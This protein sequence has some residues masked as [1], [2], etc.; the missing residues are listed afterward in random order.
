M[1]QN[2]TTD[3]QKLIKSIFVSKDEEA[4]TNRKAASEI[5]R[6]TFK[7]MVIEEAKK[8]R[9][10]NNASNLKTIRVRLRNDHISI[11]KFKE[12]NNDDIHRHEEYL[13]QTPIRRA[14]KTASIHPFIDT[15]T[16]AIEDPKIN[17]TETERKESLVLVPTFKCRYQ[18][19][20]ESDVKG[21]CS[22]VAENCSDLKNATVENQEPKN[23]HES[24]KNLLSISRQSNDVTGQT[25]RHCATSF[26]LTMD[27]DNTVQHTV[28]LNPLDKN[29]DNS[30][31]DDY[32]SVA[33]D[34]LD[35]DEIVHYKD[36][37]KTGHDVTENL[38]DHTATQDG[39]HLRSP[40]SAA[41]DQFQLKKTYSADKQDYDTYT[42]MFLE[43]VLE[44]EGKIVLNT[45]ICKGRFQGSTRSFVSENRDFCVGKKTK[46]DVKNDRTEQENNDLM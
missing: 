13:L 12:G 46:F 3:Y 21:N 11:L 38:F 4:S 39:N 36:C 9:S 25:R 28:I 35:A 34:L 6:V 5:P 37:L 18:S 15:E 10:E 27:E 1:R 26:A 41:I 40:K 42:T 24:Q 17:I 33:E 22:K 14:L 29:K 31:L 23:A 20:V 7:K 30:V 19:I 44:Q 8:K 2:E 45:N 43:N 32:E 16:N